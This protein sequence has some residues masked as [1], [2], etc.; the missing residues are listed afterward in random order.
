MTSHG[1]ELDH[2]MIT[3]Q[4]NIDDMNP[5]LYSHVLER[6][7]EAGA[8]DA[9]LTPVI[10]KKGR[11]GIVLN[12]LAKKLKLGALEDIIFRETTTLGVRYYATTCHRLERKFQTVHTPWGDIPVKIGLKDG[13]VVNVAPEY[14][15]CVAAAKKGKKPLK[16][17]YEVVKQNL[18]V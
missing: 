17:I 8:K 12:I 16:E 15:D 9:Y 7:L 5:E 14:Q 4:A 10:M 13:D 1:E 6:L 18:K 3:I 11:P 2:D